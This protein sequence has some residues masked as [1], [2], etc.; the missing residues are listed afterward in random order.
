MPTTRRWRRHGRRG[1]ASKNP[2]H[3]ITRPRHRQTRHHPRTRPASQ[4]HRHRAHQRVATPHPAAIS[5]A[6]RWCQRLAERASW[7]RRVQT[8]EPPNRQPQPDRATADRQ[9]R[10]PAVVSA[11][12]RRRGHR[13]VRAVRSRRQ[14]ARH[15]DNPVDHSQSGFPRSNLV[16]AGYCPMLSRASTFTP[17]RTPAEWDGHSAET[18]NLHGI[19]SDPRLRAV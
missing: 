14:S 11:V 19:E 4:S 15:L 9:I 8:T 7:A 16:A 2:Q 17:C 3:C 18:S 12:Q 10:Q 13:A 5:A 6:N 1:T